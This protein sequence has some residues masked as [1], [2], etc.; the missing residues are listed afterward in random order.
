MS[1]LRH[2][3]R[4]APSFVALTT[5]ACN[6][7][8]AAQ[9][10]AAAPDA[11]V[12][13]VVRDAA[14]PDAVAPHDAR[15]GSDAT[16]RPP[17]MTADVRVEPP[18]AD[19]ATMDATADAATD[20]A[21]P[22]GGGEEP[23]MDPQPVVCDGRV[24]DLMTDP[25]HCGRC[26]NA[27]DAEHGE[28]VAGTCTCAFG[29]TACGADNTCADTDFDANNCGACGTVCAAGELCLE[30]GC[31]CRPGLIRCAGVC[32]DTDT[33]PSHCGGCGMSC[34]GKAC[35][36][37]DCENRNNCPFGTFTCQTP[38]GLACVEGRESD[39]HCGPRITD[40][41]GTACE[42]DQ[43]CQDPGLFSG[44]SCV[45]YRPGLGCTECPC[46]DCE[47]GEAC[48]QTDEVPDVAFCVRR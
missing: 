34:N 1:S 20:A 15:G 38:G 17:D 4:F 39:L 37:G 19:P 27:C 40:P 26:E 23:D 12:D 7:D 6:F 8:P 2:F 42:G 25:E 28:C 30:G 3:K 41:C 29:A 24:V 10:P 9:P 35:V 14:V 43:F 46:T 5:L 32:V 18:D 36:D 13:A 47:D 48:V 16:N 22:D 21:T 45:T 33:D 31:V 44:P 11:Q